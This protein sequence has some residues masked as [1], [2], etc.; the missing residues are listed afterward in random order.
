MKHIFTRFFMASIFNDPDRE[1]QVLY[2]PPAVLIKSL[3]GCVSSKQQV[4]FFWNCSNVRSGIH[5]H[6]SSI[7]LRSGSPF[8]P[9]GPRGHDCWSSEDTPR[10]PKILTML[11]A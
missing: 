6:M 10:S 9:L 11:P 1:I 4:S 5:L 8:T 2:A 3:A 7:P